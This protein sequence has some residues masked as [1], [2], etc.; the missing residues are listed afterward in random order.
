MKCFRDLK[1]KKLAVLALVIAGG[2]T[3]SAV[4]ELPSWIRNIEAGSALQAVFFRMMSLPGGAVLFRRPPRETRPALSDLIQSQPGKAELYSLR[5]LEDEQQLDFAAAE[6]DWKS[7]VEQSS[8][9]ISAE[10]A[11]A[12]FYHRRLRPADEIKILSLVANAPPI[13]AEKLT[14][15]A[16]QQSWKSFDRI[17]GIIQEQGL[18]KEVSIAQCQA[19]IARYPHEQS[20]YA[21]FLQFLVSQK[22]YAAAGK[23]IADYSQQ[24]PNDKIFPVKAKAMIEYRQ[25]SVRE[26]LAVYEQTFQPLWDPELVKSYF[27]LL[28]ETQNLRKF[29]DQT[30]AALNANP[31]DLN[32]TARLFYYYQQQGKLDVAQQA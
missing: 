5:A 6:S 28:R 17:F 8:D 9:K 10:L 14:S 12:D 32:A 22:E 20:L 18:P 15:P 31:E 24:F 19:W 30:R 23:L 29:L 4:G 26:G 27:D 3:F 13:A 2:L 1:P 11:L 7:Y 25:G 16:E 21:R